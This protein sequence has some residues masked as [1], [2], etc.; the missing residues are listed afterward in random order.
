MK[1]EPEQHPQQLSPTKD[2]DM[3]DSVARNEDE[4][5]EELPLSE[6]EVMQQR[7]VNL[8]SCI[9]KMA[10]YNGGNNPKI[11]REF[12]IEPWSP[13]KKSMTKY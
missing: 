8:E 1:K 9:A 5:E 7:I 13:D 10:H 6:V 2:N 12:G 11:C 4:L 3:T